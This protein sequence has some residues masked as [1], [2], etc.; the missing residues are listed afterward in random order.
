MILGILLAMNFSLFSVMNMATVTER[1]EPLVTGSLAWLHFTKKENG[2]VCNYCKKFIPIKGGNTSGLIRHIPVHKEANKEYLKKKKER[3]EKKQHDENEKKRKS[4]GEEM[5]NTKQQKLSFA[6][7]NE[8]EKEIQT[9][10]NDALLDYVANYGVS[11]H[12]AAGLKDVM[13]V[14]NKRIKVP[15]SWTLARQSDDKGKSVLN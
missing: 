12:Q 1:Q 8:A 10:F 2:G 4:G 6:K 7:P 3:E 11:V 5:R 9:K 13:A 15:S 14:A